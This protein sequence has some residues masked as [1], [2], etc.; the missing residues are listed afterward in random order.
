[1]MKCR[2]KS[3]SMMKNNILVV[4]EALGGDFVKTDLYFLSRTRGEW[5][6]I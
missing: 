5:F 2:F 3:K 6:D 1:M 4:K